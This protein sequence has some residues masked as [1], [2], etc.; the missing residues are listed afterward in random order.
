MNQLRF[1]TL[2]DYMK[3]HELNAALITSPKNVFYLTGF[4]S[5]PYERFLGLIVP[6]EGEPLL[7]LPKLDLEAAQQG[8]NIEHIV[9]HSDTQNPYEILKQKLPLGIKKLGIENG[10]LLV[11]R[12]EDLQKAIPEVEYADI[13]VPLQEMRTIKTEDEVNCLRKAVQISEHALTIAINN[14]KIG[15]TELDVVAELEYQLKKNGSIGLTFNPIVLS[16][17]KT[18]L[19]HGVSGQRTIQAGELLMVDL[20][21][22]YGGYYSDIT[23]TFAVGEINEGLKDMYQTVLNA[24]IAAITS[25]KPGVTMASLDH[26]AR[27]VIT[28]NGYGEYFVHRV[29]HGIGIDN[30]ELPSIHGKSQEYLKTGM[31]FTIEPGIYLP[32]IGGVR[33]EDDILVTE[34]GPEVLSP[35]PKELTIIG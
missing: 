3:E 2:R 13:G 22:L 25:V 29:G 15:M 5:R 19:P 27:N 14:F 4:L 18:S 20:T 9:T 32:G 31:T 10:E 8:S 26:A 24:N 16:G 12:L 28:E 23:R 33:I 6:V 7:L 21:A 17:E 30:H 11:R 35:F 1:Q 34:N